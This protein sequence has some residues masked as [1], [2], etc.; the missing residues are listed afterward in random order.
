MKINFKNLQPYLLD[1]LSEVDCIYINPTFMELELQTTEGCVRFWADEENG[2]AKI[3]ME[4]SEIPNI[5]KR[6]CS[7]V[8]TNTHLADITYTN[9][10]VEL[11]FENDTMIMFRLEPIVWYD[12]D[13]TYSLDD[14]ELKTYYTKIE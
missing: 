1:T 10:A 14:L 13:E 4:F 7:E 5:R 2:E 11:Y 9:L 3:K 12:E 6:G 8:I